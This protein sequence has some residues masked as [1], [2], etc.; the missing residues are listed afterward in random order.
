MGAG[1]AAMAAG[2]LPAVLVASAR[3]ETTRPHY[4]RRHPI[5]TS[6]GSGGQLRLNLWMQYSPSLMDARP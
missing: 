6:T 2:L 4:Q 1:A 5:L 3:G